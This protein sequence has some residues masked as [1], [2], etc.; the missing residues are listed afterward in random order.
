[1]L[2]GADENLILATELAKIVKEMWNLKLF[3]MIRLKWSQNKLRDT[4]SL[5]FIARIGYSLFYKDNGV[6]YNKL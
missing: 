4:R 6:Q 2:I 5:I 1:M 3:L